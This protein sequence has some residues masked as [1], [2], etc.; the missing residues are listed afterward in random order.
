MHVHT[1]IH[2]LELK[3]PGCVEEPFLARISMT[4]LPFMAQHCHK[5][6]RCQLLCAK[7]L[8]TETNDLMEKKNLL[9]FMS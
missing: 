5:S 3:L 7:T 9:F 6:Q 8:Q 1:T 2:F 4:E